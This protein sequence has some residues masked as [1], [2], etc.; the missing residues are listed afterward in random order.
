MKKIFILSLLLP[1]IIFL[2][3]CSKKPDSQNQEAVIDLVASQ[4]IIDSSIIIQ[5]TSTSETQKSVLADSQTD[6]QSSVEVDT[7]EKN[8]INQPAY[9][10]DVYSSNGKNFIDVDYVEW[11]HGE[12]SL[13]AQVE[14][15][16][17]I[18]LS[19]CYDYPNG[20]KRNKNPKV[21]TFE[22]S[23]SVNIEI[24]GS[25]GSTLNSMG[26]RLLISFQ[27][28]EKIA[29]ELKSWNI[30]YT[31]PFKKPLTFVTIEVK[32]GVVIKITEPYQE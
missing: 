17:C 23:S 12:A 7:I 21:R 28:F 24:S 14:D 32:D 16:Q 11:L 25:M 10:I 13:R 8:V 27:E 2:S 29:L 3:G 26:E 22:V 4:K 19:E 18:S 30:S 15:G 1:A 31:P 9:L 5:S 20:Y 6:L